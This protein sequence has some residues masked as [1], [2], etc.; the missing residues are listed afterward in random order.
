[1]L[2]WLSLL[3][4]F[5]GYAIGLISCFV[6]LYVADCAPA[7][8]RGAL[9]SCY[10]FAIG[11]G[12]ILGVGVDNSTKNREGSGA[13]RIPMGIQLVFPALLIPSLLFLA[14]ESPR[15]LVLKK[16]IPEA[17]TALGKLKRQEGSNNIQNELEA[18]QWSMQHDQAHG[19]GSWS[20]IFQ[21]GT[22]GRKAY[23]GFAIQ[24]TLCPTNQIKIN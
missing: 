11:I 13:F 4:S 15:W 1:M 6:P 3:T 5:E 7:H 23:L 20:E 24:G 16:R 14:P 18:I 12:L 2:F 22:E 19:G 8:L 9:V 21:W 10:Q 17:K